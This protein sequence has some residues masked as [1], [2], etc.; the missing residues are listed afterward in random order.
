LI[1]RG[2][3]YDIFKLNFLTK[4]EL[5]ILLDE[6]KIIPGH[7]VKMVSLIEYIGE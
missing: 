5:E 2:F 1:S 3:G 7:R 4:K 6:I